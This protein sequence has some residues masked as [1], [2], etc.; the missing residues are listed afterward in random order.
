V[1]LYSRTTTPRRAVPLALLALA[2]VQ[3]RRPGTRVELFGDPRQAPNLLADARDLS[4]L[5]RDELAEAYSR[6][7]VGVV[8]SLT[9][10]SLIAQEMLACGL[11]CVEADTPSTRAAFGPEPPLELAKLTVQGIADAVERLLADRELRDHRRHEGIDFAHAHT[12]ENA[13]EAV[14]AGL[15]EAL[16]LA[17]E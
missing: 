12:W 10:Y 7:T 9:N 4:V 14:E 5:G 3:R 6:A 2:E 1:L 11:P 17:G 13:A 8:L 15:R 16:R